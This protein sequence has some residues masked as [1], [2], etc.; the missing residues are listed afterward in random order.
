MGQNR[1]KFR[2]LHVKNYSSSKKYTT[3]GCGGW[4]MLKSTPAWK[5]YPTAGLAVLYMS[6]DVRLFSLKTPY[7]KI[8]YQ[9][10]F[11][12]CMTFSHM[13]ACL[14][15]FWEDK[16]SCLCHFSSI[17]S[18]TDTNKVWSVGSFSIFEESWNTRA[19]MTTALL[20]LGIDIDISI[21]HQGISSGI[22]WFWTRFVKSVAHDKL[23][24]AVV[25][26]KIIFII[27]RNWLAWN[28]TE[29]FQ[30]LNNGVAEQ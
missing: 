19:V 5:K 18:D 26:L 14:N 22:K 21:D 7:C 27:F 15:P 9:P 1:P 29:T 24:H 2:I 3:A 30:L 25:A 20:S 16:F 6:Y 12:L 11:C 13:V 4:A 10:V 17:L 28:Q 8:K 23:I